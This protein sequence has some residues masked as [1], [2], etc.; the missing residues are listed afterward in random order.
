MPPARRLRPPQRRG[1]FHRASPGS[2]Q[3]DG[4]G[5]ALRPPRRRPP[6]EGIDRPPVDLRG[7]ASLPET[8]QSGGGLERRR[9]R[10]ADCAPPLSVERT[11]RGCRLGEPTTGC[12]PDDSRS[13]WLAS[14]CRTSLSK[15]TGHLTTAIPAQF[16]RW[17]G[18]RNR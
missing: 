9:M 12:G 11:G 8:R 14:A 3:R 10:I 4:A 7:T 15:L 1:E 6:L 16:A 2:V 5:R 13:S 18:S 17:K